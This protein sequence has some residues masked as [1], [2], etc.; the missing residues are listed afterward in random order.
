M[1]WFGILTEVRATAPENGFAPSACFAPRAVIWEA[2][3]RLRVERMSDIQMRLL[4]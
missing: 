2:E 3:E 4:E 1:H